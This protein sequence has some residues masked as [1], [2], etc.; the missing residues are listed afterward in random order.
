[1]T[2]IPLTDE[3]RKPLRFPIA[4]AIIIAVN[5]IVFFVELA[6]G[7]KF[8]ERWALVP[9]HVASPHGFATIFTSM[10]MHASWVHIIGNMVFFWAFG[11]EVEDAMG[12]WRYLIFYLLGGVAASIAQIAVSP[13]STIPN[14]GASGAIAAVMGAFIVTYPTDRIKSILVIFWFVMVREI[15]A[16]VLIGI[17]FLLQLLSGI[18]SLVSQQNAGGVAYMAHVGGFLFGVIAAPIF[19]GRLSSGGYPSNRGPS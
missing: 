15:P 1:M 8:I 17:W 2:A 3:D 18:G 4:T 7:S 19:E 11:P 6:E 12:S 5:F 9:A 13:G 10:F 16:I 14:L